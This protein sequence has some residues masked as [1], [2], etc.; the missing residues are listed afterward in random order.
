MSISKIEE[1]HY[2]EDA[3]AQAYESERIAFL[4][5]NVELA[6]AYS[7]I[8]ELLYYKLREE[9]NEQTKTIYLQDKGFRLLWAL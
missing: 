6:D 3:I 8:A 7:L 5:G 9:N 1:C 2:A 4:A